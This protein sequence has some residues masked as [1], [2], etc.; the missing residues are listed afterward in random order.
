MSLYKRNTKRIAVCLLILSALDATVKLI[1]IN[2]LPENF[3]AYFTVTE[4]LYGVIVKN[5]L[6]ALCAVIGL[7][8]YYNKLP[9]KFGL[10]STNVICIL[11]APLIVLT[12]SGSLGSRLNAV[13]DATMLFSVFLAYTFIQANKNDYDWGK[14]SKKHPLPITIRIRSV[15]EW[16]NPYLVEPYRVIHDRIATTI[17]TFLRSKFRMGPLTIRLLCDAPL[18][19]DDKKNII[20]STQAYF[21]GVEKK[22]GKYLEKRYF[23]III[24]A[25]VCVLM[26]AVIK[27]FALNDEQFVIWEILMNFVAFGLW[28]IGYVHYERSEAYGEALLSRIAKKATFVFEDEQSTPDKIAPAPDR[29]PDDNA[30][31][32]DDAARPI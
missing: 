16:F 28:Q 26:S 23:R 21:N 29:A 18:T 14:V 2:F 19:E 31:A 5:A 32:C 3:P 24:L 27:R 13:V 17:M 20:A 30:A 22:H 6:G 1:L 12:T 9:F 7:L 10:I 25:F 8:V 11:M 4:S 15:E